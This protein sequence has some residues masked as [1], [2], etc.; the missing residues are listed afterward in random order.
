MLRAVAAA[1]ALVARRREGLFGRR[2]SLF[3]DMIGS[4]F[5]RGF[6]L[7]FGGRLDGARRGG[8]TAGASHLVGGGNI[9]AR[10]VAALAGR[11]L[12]AGGRLGGA[13]FFQI[14]ARL[15]GRVAEVQLAELHVL[16]PRLARSIGLPCPHSAS[17]IAFRARSKS[18]VTSRFGSPPRGLA[19]ALRGIVCPLADIAVKVASPMAE[20]LARQSVL[21]GTATVKAPRMIT[22]VGFNVPSLSSFLAPNAGRRAPRTC[23]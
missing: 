14:A 17:D 23:A 12:L 8:A 5:A 3:G 6:Q 16:R 1:R 21:L 22:N 18:D 4:R 11:G 7:S 9:G 15:F 2:G 20:L 13:R 10:F 19:S